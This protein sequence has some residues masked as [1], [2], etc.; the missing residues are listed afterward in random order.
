MNTCTKT[1]PENSELLT[2]S[3]IVRQCPYQYIYRKVEVCRFC[4][5]VL[6]YIHTSMYNTYIYIYTYIHIYIHTRCIEIYTRY[7]QTPGDG[8]PGRLGAGPGQAAAG[9]PPG[10]RRLACWSIEKLHSLL[11]I[12]KISILRTPSTPTPLLVF[13]LVCRKTSLIHCGISPRTEHAV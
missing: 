13:W 12:A 7:I 10:R 1:Q 4:T 5:N 8:R 9:P 6:K 3:C 2:I 11:I